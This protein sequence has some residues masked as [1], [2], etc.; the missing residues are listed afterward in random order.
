AG[1]GRADRVDDERRAR[2]EALIGV[3]L[4]GEEEGVLHARALYGDGGVLGVLLDDREQIAE[5]PAL[6]VGEVGADDRRVL[7]GMR[8]AVDRHPLGGRAGT[9][10]RRRRGG[11]RRGGGRDGGRAR[12]GGG[13][14]GR[15]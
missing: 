12:P 4:A 6:G 5:Q 2:L 9:V 1:R 14:D 10:E 7:L 13:A 15:S 3:V 8:D 11:R